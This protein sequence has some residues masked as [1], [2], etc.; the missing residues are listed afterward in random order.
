MVDYLDIRD[1]LNIDFSYPD[2]VFTG[3]MTY[4]TLFL[5][6]AFGIVMD[7]KLAS[8]F[9]NAY[10][11]DAGFKH[12]YERPYFILIGTDSIDDIF[13]EVDSD[14]RE[15]PNF[16]YTYFVGTNKGKLLYMYVF[17]CPP[18]YKDDYDRFVEGKY[19][20]F[21]TDYKSKF[22]RIIPDENGNFIESHLYGVIYKTPSL[23]RK[24][25]NLLF[26]D[27]KE[28]LDKNQ[29]YF[30]KPDKKVETFR[31]MYIKN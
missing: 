2:S 26:L 11:N 3:N 17:E 6:P 1:S 24:V 7:E 9:I 19:S 31:Y 15:N 12:L 25:E 20:T 8:L 10:L 22:A 21:S 13:N 27:P 5:P 28:K 29:E 14:F 18:K 23:K 30:G 4:S 16:V